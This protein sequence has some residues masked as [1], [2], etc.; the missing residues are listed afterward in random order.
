MLGFLSLWL[1][2][3]PMLTMV[4]LYAYSQLTCKLPER[5]DISGELLNVGTSATA[6]TVAASYRLTRS[7]IR[8]CSSVGVRIKSKKEASKMGKWGKRCSKLL[9]ENGDA[10][11]PKDTCAEWCI[12]PYYLSLLFDFMLSA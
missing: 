11:Y 10:I 1:H 4:I 6:S 8:L 2:D 7:F 9:P 5:E 12:I 3:F